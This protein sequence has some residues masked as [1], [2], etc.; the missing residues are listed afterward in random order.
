MITFSHGLGGSP[1][2][3]NPEANCQAPPKAVVPCDSA[4]PKLR[5]RAWVV[6]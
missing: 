5:F 4:P 3:A 2:F 6:G 1:T